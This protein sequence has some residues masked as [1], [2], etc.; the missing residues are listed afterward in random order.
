MLKLPDGTVR[1]LVRACKSACP[2]LRRWKMFARTWL[3]EV[4]PFEPET[5]ANELTAADASGVSNNRR[6]CEA[7]QEAGRRCPG[8]SD[9]CRMM[10]ARLRE[11]HSRAADRAQGSGQAIPADRGQFLEAARTR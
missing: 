5:V 6:I 10:P 9:R 2:A 3:D 8:R 4:D 7:E 11:Y 1:V